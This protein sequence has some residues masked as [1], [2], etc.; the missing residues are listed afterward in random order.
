MSTYFINMG[1]FPQGKIPE[2]AANLVST[3][4]DWGPQTNSSQVNVSTRSN[5]RKPTQRAE[6]FTTLESWPFHLKLDVTVIQQQLNTTAEG[7]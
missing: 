4:S 6:K 1:M 5:T 2:P 3:L 7:G